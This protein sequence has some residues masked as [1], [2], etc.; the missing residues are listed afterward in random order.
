VFFDRGAVERVDFAGPTS[1]L[2][3]PMD[4][5][6]TPNPINPDQDLDFRPNFVRLVDQT[7]RQFIVGLDDI[8][9]GIEDLTVFRDNDG[10]GIDELGNVKL[11]R[12]P[13]GGNTFTLLQD[14]DDYLLR[15]NT[16]TKQI[17]FDAASGVF[18]IGEYVVVLNTAGRS[19]WSTGNWSRIPPYPASTPD[20]SSPR[21]TRRSETSRAT[22]CCPTGPTAPR[23]S[24]SSC[25][26]PR[27]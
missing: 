8:G 24:R 27:S 12:R 3:A 15:Y 2:I 10:N 25:N 21:P 20:C 4:I 19:R 18:P 7:V 26:P 9:I 13:D 14:Q 17:T 6:V 11:L 5:S 22:R 1:A 23:G 16:N